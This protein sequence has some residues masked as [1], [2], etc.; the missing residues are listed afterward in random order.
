MSTLRIE[1]AD[2]GEVLATSSLAAFVAANKDGLSRK[3]IAAVSS[4]EVNESTTFGG[5][6]GDPIKVVR[7]A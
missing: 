3:Q 5:G 1:D 4:L 7:V 6:A 2:S